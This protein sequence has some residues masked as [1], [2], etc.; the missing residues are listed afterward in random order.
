MA[1]MFKPFPQVLYD[2]KK[3]GK[4]ETVTNIMLRFKITEVLRSRETSFVEYTVPDGNRPDNVAFSLYGDPTLSWLILMTNNIVDPLF[5]WPLGVKDFESYLR[6][7]YGS[8]SAAHSTVHE[9]RKILNKQSV[10]FDGTVV[11]RRTLIVDETTYNTLSE[12]DRESISKYQYEDELNNDRR[13][14]LYI[15]SSR[16]SNILSDIEDIFE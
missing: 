12:P 7:K 6:G 3:N 14:I 11:P 8:L 15:P 4:L 13:N 2:I 1:Y 5:E 10:L 9:Y 16:I